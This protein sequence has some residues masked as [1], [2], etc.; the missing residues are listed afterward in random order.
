[1]N[2]DK[3]YNQNKLHQILIKDG[4]QTALD[5]SRKSIEMSFKHTISRLFIQFILD[6]NKI[7]TENVQL[8]DFQTFCENSIVNQTVKGFDVND[9]SHVDFLKKIV[10]KELEFFNE[11]TNY[12]SFEFSETEILKYGH[13]DDF[14]IYFAYQ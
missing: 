7:A 8:K 1:M 4:N 6:N 12:T 2:W 14:S 13:Y 10:D 11:K 9:K 5:V 3:I